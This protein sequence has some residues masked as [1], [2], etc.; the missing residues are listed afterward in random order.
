MKVIAEDWRDMVAGSQGFL[1][2]RGR[3]GLS[4][5]EVVWGEMDS[6]VYWHIHLPM[7]PLFVQVYEI[8]L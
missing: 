3:D 1:T 5:Q 2:G 4:R 8:Y 7:R 6:M